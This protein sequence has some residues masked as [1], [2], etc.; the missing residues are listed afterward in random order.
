MS[1]LQLLGAAAAAAIGTNWL[2]FARQRRAEA[3][4]A[5]GVRLQGTVV[6]LKALP[7][8]DI[9]VTPALNPVVRYTTPE[10]QTATFTSGVGRYP[11][12]YTIGQQVA[13]RYQPARQPPAELEAEA[14]QAESNTMFVV[15]GLV[16]WG[17]ALVVLFWDGVI[18]F[19]E[20]RPHV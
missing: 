5:D 7:Q 3:R 17:V 18:G 13:V 9:H 14:A 11:S 10:G 4:L 19:L 12:P 8:A 2:W 1:V 15:F 16:F 6:E 20:G